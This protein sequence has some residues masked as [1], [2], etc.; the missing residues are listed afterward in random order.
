MSSDALVNL[1]NK[2]NNII[3]SGSVEEDIV[4]SENTLEWIL[5]LDPQATVELQIAGLAH[6]IDRAIAPSVN[7]NP[8][9]SYDEYKNRHSLRS[10]EIMKKIMDEEKVP[11]SFSKRVVNLITY[12]EVGGDSET[13]TLRDADS[14]SYFDKC[15]EIYFQKR[16]LEPTK[17]KMRFM[18]SRSSSRAK[19]IILELNIHNMILEKEIRRLFSN[20][21]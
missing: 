6:D 1:N 8:D 20:K 9:E 7:Q 18:Y 5:K 14:I 10:A 13:D 11:E 21:N 12:H 4:H 16:G 2:I 17:D 3:Q 19:K 15:I